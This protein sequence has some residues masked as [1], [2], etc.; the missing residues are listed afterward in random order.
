VKFEVPAADGIPEIAPA[1]LSDSPAGS[2]PDATD[3]VYP[4]VPPFAA[5]VCE[6]AAP[7]VPL[8][9][10]EVAIASAG[11][12]IAS[13]NGAVAVVPAESC[14]CTVKFEVPAAD[15]IPEIAPAPLSD[16]PAGSEP[17]ATDHLYPPLPPVAASVCE[18]AVPTVPLGS[19]EVATASAGLIAIERLPVALSPAESVTSTVKPKSPAAVGVPAIVPDALSESAGGSNPDASDHTF[20]PLPPRADSLALYGTPMLPPGNELVSMRN[21][22]AAT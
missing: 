8:G 2:E 16:S 11:G 4:P 21:A 18:Y 3:H 5:S 14:T 17:E 20:P 13:D 12:S 9:S 10:E 15:G 1:P 7:T 6:Y 22:G 19:D